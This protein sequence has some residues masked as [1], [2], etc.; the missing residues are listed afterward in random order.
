VA[1]IS[2]AKRLQAETLLERAQT[3]QGQYWDLLSELEE[4]LGVEIDGTRDL[5]DT[6]IDGLILE[7]K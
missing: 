7:G 2:K 3:I 6:D 1:R 4:I 5:N